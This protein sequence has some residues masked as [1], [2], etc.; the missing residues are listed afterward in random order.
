MTDVHHLITKQQ[1]TPNDSSKVILNWATDRGWKGIRK[2]RV[3]FTQKHHDVGCVYALT[4]STREID[5]YDMN[6]VLQYCVKVGKTRHGIGNRMKNYWRAAVYGCIDWCTVTSSLHSITA[7]T[8]AE[9]H[10]LHIGFIPL[11]WTNITIIEDSEFNLE[12]L[13]KANFRQ[14]GANLHCQHPGAS[15][16]EIFENLYNKYG[17]KI[18]EDYSL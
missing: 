14:L 3:K 4:L 8:I 12:K 16:M 10:S 15:Q 17:N 6:D 11:Q 2:P 13:W 1:F 5:L 9:G 18:L 7:K